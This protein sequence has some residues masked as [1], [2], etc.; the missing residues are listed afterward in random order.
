MFASQPLAIYLNDHLA[1]A[2]G[3]VELIRRIARESRDTVAEPATR[4]LATEI[5][6]DREVLTRIMADLD[7]GIDRF[8]VALG[9]VGEKAARLK[10]NGRVLT[11]S[12]LSLLLEI[13]AMRLGVEG[14]ICL[15]RS[16]LTL[17]A[18]HPELN[19]VELT[20]LSELGRRQADELESLRVELAAD[21]LTAP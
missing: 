16:L 5:S 6:A 11:R 7:I 10:T 14:K 19:E 15:W 17:V 12:P 3:G 18:R 8:R 9:W 13:E 20:R 21:R 1:G 4:R 2:T